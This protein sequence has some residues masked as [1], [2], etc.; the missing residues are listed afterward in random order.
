MRFFDF[1]RRNPVSKEDLPVPNYKSRLPDAFRQSSTCPILKRWI[2]IELT[3]IQTLRAVVPALWENHESVFFFVTAPLLFFLAAGD[4]SA[5]GLFTWS[6]GNASSPLHL[7]HP[8]TELSGPCSVAGSGFRA[9][10]RFVT[11]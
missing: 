4:S 3:Q 9:I 7:F 6:Q 8:A 2:Q 1:S 10:F 11:G 5:A